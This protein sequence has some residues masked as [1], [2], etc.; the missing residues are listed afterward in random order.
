MSSTLA[1]VKDGVVE[2]KAIESTKVSAKGT[3]NLGKDAFLQLLVAQMQYQD[4]LE[5][6]SD[7]EWISQLATY[8]S[9]EEMQNLNATMSAAQAFSMVGKTVSVKTDNGSVEGV[10]DFVTRSGNKTFVSVNG[11]EYKVD[12]VEAVLGETYLSAAHGPQVENATEYYDFDNK[13][14]IKFK[15]SLGEKGYEATGLYVMVNDKLVDSEQISY[16][17]DRKT[18]TIKAGA[19]DDI[20]TTGRTYDV[21]FIFD[22]ASQTVISDKAKITVQ[23]KQPETTTEETETTGV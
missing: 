6:S 9:L 15:V 16:D 5:P 22:N 7:T 14:D 13:K 2:N 1:A 12:D 21:S 3:T 20:V 19:L 17:Q 8:S 11:S 10:V 18:L 4:P 23:G